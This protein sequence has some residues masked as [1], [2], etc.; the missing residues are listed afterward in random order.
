[1]HLGESA[2]YLSRRHP[3]YCT[4]PRTLRRITTVI[5]YDLVEVREYVQAISLRPWT[6]K[7]SRKTRASEHMRAAQ[8]SGRGAGLGGAG[9]PN[10]RNY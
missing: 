3:A 8:A 5:A 2:I 4:F 6:L 10:A 7:I 1:M 9:E